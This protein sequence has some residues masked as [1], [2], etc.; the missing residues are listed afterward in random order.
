LW[1]GATSVQD[2]KGPNFK[3]YKPSPAVLRTETNYFD[4]TTKGVVQRSALL[5]GLTP[6]ISTS[7][8]YNVAYNLQP[9]RSS[10]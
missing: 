9:V 3:Y 1:V 8:P 7:L 6:S 4:P 2:P 5:L 10:L